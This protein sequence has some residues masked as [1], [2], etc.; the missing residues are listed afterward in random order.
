[1]T[2][3]LELMLAHRTDSPAAFLRRSIVATQYYQCPR[4]PEKNKTTFANIKH[5]KARMQAQVLT[6]PFV[7]T[8]GVGSGFLAASATGAFITTAWTVSVGFAATG[9][10]SF[11]VFLWDD[12]LLTG[13]CSRSSVFLSWEVFVGSGTEFWNM[14]HS[15]IEGEMQILVQVP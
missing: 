7:N 15:L 6:S 10:Q 2:C 14:Q 4:L 11:S 12:P 1:M 13:N 3:A 8:V 9:T 5:A